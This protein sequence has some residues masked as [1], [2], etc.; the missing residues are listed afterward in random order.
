MS[1]D[2]RWMQEA[3]KEARAA[4]AEDEVPVGAVVV[5]DGG[6]VARAHNLSRQ[7]KDPTLH[8]EVLA[9]REAQQQLGSLT[10]CTLYV[11]MEPCAMCA[12]AMVLMKLPRLVFGAFDSSCG[13]TG[14]RVDL[15]DHWFYHSA[16]TWGGV[17]EKEC[18]ELLTN[19]FQ[20]KR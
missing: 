4:M 17:L 16:E 19:F 11:T 1:N 14:S 10:G 12:G 18:T 8:A 3:L 15:T 13:C 6:I 9:L 7:Q 5:K 2:E 20:R